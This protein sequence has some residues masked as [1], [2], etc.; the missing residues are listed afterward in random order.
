MAI[1]KPRTVDV[2]K[3]DARN[4]EARSRHRRRHRRGRGRAG[5]WVGCHGRDRR[6][7]AVRGVRDELVVAAGWCRAWGFSVNQGCGRKACRAQPIS[8]HGYGLEPRGRSRPF[9]R[10][11]KGKR[12]RESEAS[13]SLGRRGRRVRRA[14]RESGRR[15]TSWEE[16]TRTRLVRKEREAAARGKKPR[17]DAR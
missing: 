1:G 4:S 16:S 14:G 11:E 9:R 17:F 5:R 7:K 3:A 8:T 6:A 13:G 12:N 2:A 10:D 15:A